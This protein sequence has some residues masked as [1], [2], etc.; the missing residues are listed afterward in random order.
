TEDLGA[1]ELFL[2]GSIVQMRA[3]RSH[4]VMTGM[5]ERVDAFVSQSPVFEAREG[6][7]GRVLARYPPQGN[8]LVS[9]YLLGEEHLRGRATAVE[10][11]HGRGRVLL[12]G[13]RPQWRG[14]PFGTFRILFNALLDVRLPETE[15]VEGWQLPLA[16]S[17]EPDDSD[18]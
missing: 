14:Q 2:G 8:P 18:D 6:F 10:A 12:I 17:P 4:P 7:E 9:G 1:T 15:A 3:D 16:P 11:R 5:P 13:F